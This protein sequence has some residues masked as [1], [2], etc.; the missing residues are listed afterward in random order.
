MHFLSP[1]LVSTSIYRVVLQSSH[2]EPFPLEFIPL[3]QESIGIPG[4]LQSF[5]P[6]EFE[7]VG[8]V[9]DHGVPKSTNTYNERTIYCFQIVSNLTLVYLNAADAN[10]ADTP[11]LM[12]GSY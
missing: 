6:L 9:G 3:E 10:T 12:V 1:L 7:S 4:P 5:I 8:Q 11:G 2:Y